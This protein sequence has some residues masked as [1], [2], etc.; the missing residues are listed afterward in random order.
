MDSYHRAAHPN[1]PRVKSSSRRSRSR[2]P[3]KSRYNRRS[4]SKSLDR[5]Y[6]RSSRH[7]SRSKRHDSRDRNDRRRG[8]GIGGI[9][10]TNE[11]LTMP[12]NYGNYDANVDPNY[13]NWAQNPYPQV[14]PP[15]FGYAAAAPPPPIINNNKYVLF[16]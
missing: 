9:S 8:G 6:N 14:Y 15:G 5:S 16:V 13:N 2:S 11:H 1:D 7:D 3:R 4:G 10:P 12:D